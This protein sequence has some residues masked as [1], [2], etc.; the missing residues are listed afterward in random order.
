MPRAVAAAV[1]LARDEGHVV[2]LAAARGAGYLSLAELRGKLPAGA[3]LAPLV[4]LFV[5]LLGTDQSSDVQRQQLSVRP[6]LDERNAVSIGKRPAGCP[7]GWRL[8]C[9][10]CAGAAH[11]GADTRGC[12]GALPGR[13]CAVCGEPGAA[14][15][16]SHQA[17]GRKD[18]GQDL[19]CAPSLLRA[20]PHL[21]HACIW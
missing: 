10:C 1:Q 20:C 11:V 16:G 9:Q 18:P 13:A 15:A 6:N 5:C 2:R 7:C 3:A 14:D 8:G 21:L 12:V 19:A 4:P 17:R